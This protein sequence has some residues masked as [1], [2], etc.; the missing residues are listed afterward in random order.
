M[1]A[2]ALRPD[3]RYQSAE[4]LRR[5]IERF[6]EGR[7]VSAKHDSP[8]ES[9]VKFV[10]RNKAFSAATGLG[11]AVL[12]TVVIVFVKANYAARVQ[13]EGALQLA[14]QNFTAFEYEQ[15]AKNDAIRKSI[16]GTLRAARQLADD[17]AIDDA[18]A[19][20]A[21]VRSYEP[22]NL[23]AALLRGQILLAQRKWPEAAQE[24]AFY[25]RK[26]P[27]DR[28]AFT[29][30]QLAAS[31]KTDDLVTLY[32]AADVLRKQHLFKLTPLLLAD[33]AKLREARKPLAALYDKQT[34]AALGVGVAIKENGHLIFNA[35]GVK[36]L[37][38]FKPLA[39]MQLDEIELKNCTNLADLEGL[40]GMPLK[41]L[42]ITDCRLVTSLEPLRGLPLETLSLQD[43]PKI[44][45]L[46][47][48]RGMPLSALGVDGT[49]VSNLEPLTGIKLQRL[50]AACPIADL[51][52]LRGM[53]LEF[54]S[55]SSAAVRDLEPLRGMPCEELALRS[56]YGVTS[57]EPLRG[58]PCKRLDLYKCSKIESLEPL[59]G[60]PCV[61]LNIFFTGK[62]KSLEPLRGMP[63]ERLD[64]NSCGVNDVTPLADLPLVEITLSPERI[65]H[66]MDSLRK[67]PTLK[68]F[69]VA[70]GIGRLS[71]DEFWKR[72]D[73]GEFKK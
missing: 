56:C 24:L 31:G 43:C 49:A 60:M 50:S 2:L 7:S 41:R 47:P 1:K 57:L 17:G 20:I 39:G 62:V 22:N 66:G 5:D 19:Q 44:L 36:T 54:L 33:A 40:Q 10:R 11:L 71:A 67:I 69:H 45:D 58:M 59:G 21:L 28:D 30:F 6:Q 35:T 65:E 68:Q 72:Y 26:S 27:K 55:I 70:A 29:L 51:E 34:R 16:P 18:L 48:L 32:A 25:V 12:T 15:Q 61:E 73:A 42:I 3:N 14:Q 13:A 46:E 8:W 23:Q 4:G 9:A 64:M 63:L 53:P 38:T 52:P 37:T